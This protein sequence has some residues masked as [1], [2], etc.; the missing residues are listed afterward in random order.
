MM[1]DE[2]RYAGLTDLQIERAQIDRFL[3]ALESIAASFERFTTPL[4]SNI[5]A[6]APPF[7]SQVVVS[8]ERVI[9]EG[10]G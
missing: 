7:R 3:A 6:G 8:A 5:V 2:E 9:D 1:A 10:G 4:T